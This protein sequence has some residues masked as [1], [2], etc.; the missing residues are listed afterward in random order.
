MGGS[1]NGGKAGQNPPRKRIS[2]ERFAGVITE[3]KQTWGWVKAAKTV[4]HP[5]IGDG[6]IYVHKDDVGFNMSGLPKNLPVEFF[7]YEDSR[8]LGAQEVRQASQKKTGA[9]SDE[10][11]PLPVGW[12]KHWSAE[13][14]EFY[15]W[16]TKTKETKWTE[17][18]KLADGEVLPPGW[19]KEWDAENEEWYYWH[20][21]SRTAHWELPDTAED[22]AADTQGA[23]EPVK[24]AK[25]APVLGH[26]RTEGIVTSW[27]GIW[28][29]I[30]PLKELTEDVKPLLDKNQGKV[31]I[32][33]RDVQGGVKLK[34]GMHV[35]FMIGVDHTG[36]VATGVRLHQDGD[37]NAADEEEDEQ[38]AKKSKKKASRRLLRRRLMGLPS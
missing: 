9:A 8:G 12:E 25:E 4:R 37:D 1:R 23:E 2:S 38:W 19:S 28:G 17:P 13:H 35:N 29:L 20:K 10:N 21:A 27:Q 6:R 32:N 15:Y 24:E 5:K 26:L 16:N 34:V 14:E 33:W 7:V 18:G 11:S 22:N 36:L 3:W 31:S 30:S